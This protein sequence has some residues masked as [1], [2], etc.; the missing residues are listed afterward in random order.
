[1]DA[2]QELGITAIAQTPRRRGVGRNVSELLAA[3]AAGTAIT[4]GVI[5]ALVVI[6]IVVA[7]VVAGVQVRNATPNDSCSSVI[8]CV[9]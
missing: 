8:G 3:I 6:A 5:F 7:T 4:A 9:P 1:M 2:F